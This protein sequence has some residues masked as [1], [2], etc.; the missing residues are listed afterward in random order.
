MSKRVRQDSAG[1]F[2]SRL[3]AADIRD[4][5]IERPGGFIE[6]H[7]Y[8]IN[9]RENQYAIDIRPTSKAKPVY[10]DVFIK[11]KLQRRLGELLVGDHL[12]ILL[13]GAHILPYSNSPTHLPV[14]L[15]YIEGITVLLISRPGLQGEREKLLSVWPNSPN[16]SEYSILVSAGYN[17]MLQ[18]PVKPKRESIR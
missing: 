1:P 17:H 10:L 3:N 2:L 8:S 18:R 6:G 7:I 9:P 12:R 13:Q 16:P 14:V 5:N 15:R 4:G 11:D